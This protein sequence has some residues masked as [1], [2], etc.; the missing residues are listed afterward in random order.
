MKIYYFFCCS[1]PLNHNAKLRAVRILIVF[2][3]FHVDDSDFWFLKMNGVQGVLVG[4]WVVGSIGNDATEWY[5]I[6]IKMRKSLKSFG[7]YFFTVKRR[8][9]T[10]EKVFPV[11]PMHEAENGSYSRFR[12]TE[13][14]DRK[15]IWN[16]DSISFPSLFPF[17]PACFYVESFDSISFLAF[18]SHN[19]CPNHWAFYCFL[20]SLHTKFSFSPKSLGI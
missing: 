1:P 17:F 16:I 20:F 5:G 7:K 19:L 18:H 15:A 14:E 4:W 13:L 12:M 10:L 6:E 8:S 2:G 11:A 9:R 3:V